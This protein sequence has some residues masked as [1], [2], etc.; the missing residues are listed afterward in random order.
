MCENRYR[1]FQAV[2]VCR[3]ELIQGLDCNRAHADPVKVNT[4]GN[5]PRRKVCNGYERNEEI[6]SNM[7]L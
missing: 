7:R 2:A 5:V 3:L 1:S 4:T 6:E